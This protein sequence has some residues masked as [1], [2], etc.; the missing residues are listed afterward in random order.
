ML[1]KE[2]IKAI[3]QATTVS[4]RYSD[5]K[6]TIE[7]SVEVN[8]KVYG[9][10]ELR[11]NIEVSGQFNDYG[12][13]SRELPIRECFAYCGSA[14]FIP[15][16]QSVIGLLRAGDKLTLVWTANNDSETLIDAGFSHD[17]LSLMIHRETKSGRPKVMQFTIDD[18]VCPI[19]STARM[20]R[21]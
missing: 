16:L 4:F 2:H 9:R 14:K 5:G 11:A 13:N 12:K 18:S 19:N 7:P 21:R 17:S 1:T 3:K 8:D 6:H 10:H 15:E 20:C